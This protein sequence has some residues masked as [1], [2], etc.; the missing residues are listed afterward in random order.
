M[1]K[2]QYDINHQENKISL[3]PCYNHNLSQRLSFL[4]VFRHESAPPGILCVRLGNALKP[5]GTVREVS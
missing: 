1:I 4:R 3:T 5:V 2:F